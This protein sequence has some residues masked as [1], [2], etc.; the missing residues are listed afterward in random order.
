MNAPEPA[1]SGS[2]RAVPPEVERAT[3]VII[4]AGFAGLGAAIQL[5]KQ[6]IRDI[7]IL[8]R[9][10]DVG[11]TWRDNVYPGCACDVP[12]HLYSFSFELNPDWSHH[13]A[14]QQ[15]IHDYLTRVRRKHGLDACIRFGADC[16]RSEFDEKTG[17][18]TVHAADGR[19]FVGRFLVA[20]MGPLRVPRIPDLPGRDR[21][22]GPA[23]HS[24]EWEPTIDLTGKRVGVVG[25]GASAIQVV[26]EIADQAGH[27]HVFQRTPPWVA[28]RFDPAYPDWLHGAFRAVPPLMWL[29]RALIYLRQE[30]YF[31]TAFKGPRWL[32]DAVRKMFTDHIVREMGCYDAALP[33]LP[34]YTP[35]CKRILSSS[36]WYPTLLRHDVS[37]H[38]HAVA[39]VTDTGVV[40]ANGKS[41]DLDVLIWC[42]GFVVDEPLGAAEVYG[43]GGRSLRAFWDGRPKAHLGITV[44]GFPN[45]FLLLG[46][47]TGLGHNSVVIMIEAQIR[48]IRRAIGH[49]LARGPRTWMAPKAA[50]LEAFV[51]EI[52]RAHDGLVWL[53][54]C[55]SWYLNAAG[56]NF[57]IWPASTMAYILRTLRFDA[58]NHEFGGPDR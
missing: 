21:F 17:E 12:S 35:G 15:E 57:S 49:T 39:E 28:P 19:R 10:G 25:A 44:P 13:Y 11:G 51:D 47:N 7:L 27:V 40:L 58:E 22:H 2:P 24:A 29:L 52:D 48:Y 36:D 16:T 32:R 30:A 42:T 45:L 9:A 18:W 8:E 54:G 56:D 1:P 31:F 14:G 46:P 43:S 3:V 55:T 50:A 5:R 41:V 4:G 38:P 26:P 33:V 23:M 20:G 6:G 37:L 34:T 53:S